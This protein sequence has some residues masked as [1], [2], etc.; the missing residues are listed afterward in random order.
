[1]YVGG[2]SV[3]FCVNYQFVS[4]L[5]CNMYVNYVIWRDRARESIRN[6]KIEIAAVEWFVSAMSF[7]F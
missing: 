4:A 7:E 2:K 1:M 5:V 6:L 3:C